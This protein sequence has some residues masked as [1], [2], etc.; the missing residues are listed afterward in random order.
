VDSIAAGLVRL[1]GDPSYRREIGT[2]AATII[3]NDYTWRTIAQ[4]QLDEYRRLLNDRRR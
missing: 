2:R 1:L 4:R 3:G